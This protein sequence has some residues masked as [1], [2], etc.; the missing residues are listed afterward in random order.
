MANDLTGTIFQSASTDRILVAD[1]TTVKED[2]VLSTASDSMKGIFKDVMG[3]IRPVLGAAKRMAGLIDE[4]RSLKDDKQALF[5]KALGLMGTSFPAVVGQLTESVLSKVQGPTLDLITNSAEM[6]I[7][8]VKTGGEVYRHFSNMPLDAANVFQMCNDLVG[9]DRLV[10]FINIEAETA[11]VAGLLNSVVETGLPELIDDV[12][13]LTDSD[14]VKREAMGWLSTKAVQYGDLDLVN[15]TLGVA[16]A[17]LVKLNN[18]NFA[19]DFVAAYKHGDYSID[20][21]VERANLLKT[22]LGKV[23]PDWRLTRWDGT[24]LDGY[25][26]GS[27]DFNELMM[28]TNLFDRTMVMTG[29]VY[30]KF[31]AEPVDIIKNQFPSVFIK[32]PPIQL[33][34]DRAILQRTVSPSM[35][36]FINQPN[37]NDIQIT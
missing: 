6:A 33:T 30:D 14:E 19:D 23:E 37:S 27:D 28:E 5:N 15:K 18:P 12:L 7:D 10:G 32:E 26:D 36:S 24:R 11:V 22:T 13:T 4:V 35:R 1:P 25:M 17:A 3:T 29:K 34:P 9:D 31:L 21:W 8:V 2:S 20:T 16:D